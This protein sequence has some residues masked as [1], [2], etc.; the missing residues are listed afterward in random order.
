[1]EYKTDAVLDIRGNAIFNA[2]VRVLT[3]SK[4]L[5]TIYDANGSQVNNPLG[6]D[7]TGEFSVAVPNGKYFFEISV[8]GKVYE[9][10]GPIS[11]FDP[12]DDGASSIGYGERTVSDKLGEVVSVKDAPF[13]AKGD[14]VTD[15]TAAIQ[16]AITWAQSQ[17][18]GSR[19]VLP[20]G[21][22]RTTRPLTI[23]G[24][25]S[26]ELVGTGPGSVLIPHGLAG[27]AVIDI[28][29]GVN[30][31]LS[32]LADFQ[33]AA[34]TSGTAVGIDA[35]GAT[36]W[37][38][39]NV[40]ISGMT[41]GVKVAA[42]YA[43]SFQDCYVGNCTDSAFRF[44]SMAHN[45]ALRDTAIYNCGVGTSKPMVD[46][47]EFGTEN[48]L[49]DGCDFEVGYQAIGL[50]G[51]TAFTLS[52]TY[53]EQISHS[54]FNM[55]TTPSY[56]TTI[57]AGNYIGIA[58]GLVIE[59]MHGATIDGNHFYNMPVSFGPE[60]ADIRYGV[61]YK[62]GTG[63]E[64]V[65]RLAV[66]D[67]SD[68]GNPAMVAKGYAANIGLGYKTKGTGSH[69]FTTNGG[70]ST[71]LEISGSEPSAT[72]WPVFRGGATGSSACY[73]STW[74]SADANVNL[75][76]TAKGTGRI[77]PESPT[78]FAA[79]VGFNSTMPIAKP[80]VTGSRG[81]NLALKELLTALA[82]YGLIT[83]STTS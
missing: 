51:H 47:T 19:V 71:H 43:M 12:M 56:A 50:K 58:G 73:L 62:N 54:I 27:A 37:T 2:S 45:C 79:N 53:I 17:A 14:G 65:N 49:I 42:S 9:T 72:N 24:A 59:Y 29:G 57:G 7:S 60:T 69:L 10:R 25:K 48:F 82:N 68:S 13:N 80:T 55:N 78:M 33:I 26:I 77:Q 38:V 36:A 15:D 28:D 81:G 31:N 46:F 52:N 44:T 83:D 34:P 66:H 75:K 76:I 39:R 1:M 5:A 16:A 64:L 74:G 40:R 30:S 6:T 67:A 21:Q 35:T 63:N 20:A 70:A 8:N 22:C 11:F 61:N 32:I 23:S 41:V 18:N 4:E 3:E